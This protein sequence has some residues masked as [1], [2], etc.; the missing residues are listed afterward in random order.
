[1]CYKLKET[2]MLWL[3]VSLMAV[4]LIRCPTDLSGFGLGFSLALARWA[5]AHRHRGVCD[6]A[7]HAGWAHR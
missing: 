5:E 2:K 3:C 4:Q 7:A 1:M 6:W